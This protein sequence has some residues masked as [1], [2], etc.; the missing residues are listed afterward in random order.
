MDR[1]KSRGRRRVAG[2]CCVLFCLMIGVMAFWNRTLFLEP[3]RRFIRGEIPF[4]WMKDEVGDGYTSE[5][6]RGQGELLTL[7]GGY[8]RLCG[9]T[10]FNEVQKMTNGMLTFANTEKADMTAYAENVISLYQTLAEEGIPFLYVMAPD[11]ASPAEELIP[12]GSMTDACHQNADETLAMLKTAGVP[13]LDLREILSSTREQVEAYFYR[14]DHHWNA[15][16]AFRGFQEMMGR[17]KS[18]MPEMKAENA[19]D[20]L[21][22]RHELPD[23][24]LGSHGRRV[25]A[26]FA[27]TDALCWYLPA[28]ETEMS[29]TCPG[30]V[31]RRG[32]FEQANIDRF[33]LERKNDLEMDNYH[34]YIGGDFPLILHRNQNA[35]NAKRALLIRDSFMLPLEAFLSTEFR[36]IDALDPRYYREM[37]V[38][39][40]LVMHM[41]DVVI[42]MNHPSILANGNYTDFGVLKGQAEAGDTLLEQESIRLAPQPGEEHAAAIRIQAENGKAYEL[43]FSGLER[44]EIPAV[45]AN[46][47]LTDARKE[48]EI[49]RITFDISYCE[50]N[51]FRWSFLIPEDGS[52]EYELLLYD[53]FNE[54]TVGCGLTWRGLRLREIILPEAG[55]D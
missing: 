44:S 49:S 55:A 51:G 38:S 30:F 43:T 29:L 26:F 27:G 2:F 10:R 25:G 15:D 16:G 31:F 8:A 35:E 48:K 52:G 11:K 19:D 53:G 39:E 4:S 22:I 54:E 46:A 36:E 13:C 17:L 12:A 47:V 3:L 33:F 7:N 34:V 23:W 6:L 1:E 5:R 20:A 42:M 24:W 32:S 37:T 21:W 9:R 28:F 41:P 18:M 40:Y 45:G 14:T 50:Q